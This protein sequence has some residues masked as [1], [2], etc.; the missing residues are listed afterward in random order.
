MRALVFV[1]ASGLL[2]GQTTTQPSALAVTRAYN[3]GNYTISSNIIDNRSSQ[4]RCNY[5]SYV[6][7]GTGTWS[8]TMQFQD[9]STFGSWSSFGATGVVNQASNPAIGYGN[10]YHDFIS[11]SITGSA[12]VNYSC[13]KDFYLSSSTAGVTFPV[14][15]AQG[16]TGA[17][18]LTGVLVGN[19][20]S[21]VTAVALGGPGQALVVNGAG[22]GLQFSSVSGGGGT[23]VA[24]ASDYNFAA[25]SPGGTLTSG[26]ANT[27]TLTPCPLGVN[28][29]DGSHYLYIS[30]GTGTA[31]AV[32]ITGGTCTSGVGGGT[33]IFT[34]ANNHSGAFTIAPASGGIQEAVCAL[35]VTGGDVNVPVG[36]T[37]HANVSSCGISANTNVR[38]IKST[39]AIISGTFTIFGS[40]MT[41]YS[42]RE[43]YISQPLWSSVGG[44]IIDQYR[45][46]L[47]A[48]PPFRG[49]QPGV[50]T[51]S[52]EIDV[53]SGA[54]NGAGQT[55]IGVAGY[56]RSHQLSANPVGVYGYGDTTAGYPG[57]A[58]GAN[59][60]VDNCAVDP[61]TS[62]TNNGAAGA[63]EWGIEVD[64]LNHNSP[65]GGNNAAGVVVG[66]DVVTAMETNA[67][68]YATAFRTTLAGTSS[69]FNYG[70]LLGAGSVNSYGVWLQEVSTSG[71]S[72]S[73]AIRLT[74]RDGSAV[75]HHAAV[76]AN[77]LGDWSMFTGG[78]N[79]NYYFQDSAS[80][81]ELS[82][83]QFGITI[84]GRVFSTLPACASGTEG[85]LSH[86]TDGSTNTLGATASGGGSNHV[87]IWCNGTA[88]TVFAK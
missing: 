64:V 6:A 46:S 31:E 55:Y 51:A 59:L 44:N 67:Q 39:G 32:V 66:V 3:V 57:S 74:G 69:P 2:F 62:C 19:G 71:A 36:L 34:P 52:Y 85:I 58:W 78:A 10:G 79:G 84:P 18:T 87:S 86:I 70:L 75:E 9:G 73:Q 41:G 14:T 49:H 27:V 61:P 40:G 35:G 5:H 47:G 42:S 23:G 28:G 4:R 88:W 15:V 21:P 65:L 48:Y 53:P 1:F 56:A 16:G 37:L 82:I 76:Y 50:T 38:V 30:G 7:T 80:T 13:S 22:N 83:G 17:N 43:V 77:S 45:E 33:V 63:Y 29:S 24:S 72:N 54:S 25:Q 81:L 20:T 26:I 8:V 68:T 11:F 12:K 60:V